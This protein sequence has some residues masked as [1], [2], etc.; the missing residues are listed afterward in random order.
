MGD[1]DG[2]GKPDL[3]VANNGSGTVSVYRNTT[4]SGSIGT[5]SFDAKVDFAMGT[6]PRSVAIG[7]FNGDG[8]PDLAVVNQSSNNVSVIRN[9]STIGSIDFYAKVDFTTGT[10]PQSVAVGDLDG[11][12]KPDLAVANQGSSNVSV[13]RNKSTSGSIDFYAKVDFAREEQIQILGQ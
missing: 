1:L 12:G 8:K 10:Q 5:G 2:D 13:I 3:A 7:D 11:D 6:N 4:T 9:K